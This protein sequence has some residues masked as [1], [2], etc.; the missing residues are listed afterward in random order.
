M[1]TKL[2]VT[3]EEDLVPVAK[4]FAKSRGKSLSQ[5]IED[6]LRALSAADGQTFSEEWT[7]SL[8]PAN[9][10]DERYRKLADKYL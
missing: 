5:I 8:R 3:I 6:S 7:G 2:T 9:K 1:K 10:K 4:A